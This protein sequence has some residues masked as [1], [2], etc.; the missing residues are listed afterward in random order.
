MSDESMLDKVA[1]AIC[2]GFYARK[3]P[4][5]DNLFLAGRVEKHWREYETD[6]RLVLSVIN[7]L[8]AAEQFADA[9]NDLPQTP[10]W[11]QVQ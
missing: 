8:V 5:A 3:Y 10:E 7:D 9:V 4:N 2:I 11:M 1:Q 6:A